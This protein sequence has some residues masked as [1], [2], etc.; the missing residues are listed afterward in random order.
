MSAIFKRIISWI[1][2]NLSHEWC[3]DQQES[4]GN[5][6]CGC[7]GGIVGGNAATDYLSEMC[8]GC[9]YWVNCREMEANNG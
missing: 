1:K 7:C 4:C 5:A 3:Y 2:Y 6:I 9:K 8:I